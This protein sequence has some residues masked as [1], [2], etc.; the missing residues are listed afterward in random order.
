MDL[1]IVWDPIRFR[2]D[3]DVTNGDLAIDEGG[4]RSAVLV[5]LFT[6][7]AA[8]PDYVPPAG[9]PYERRGVWVDSYEPEPAGSLL[10]LLNRVA[11]SPTL[12]NQAAGY[13]SDSLQ[14]LK[15]LRVVSA[16]D[17]QS[18]W[19]QPTVIGLQVRLT[20]PVAPPFIETFGWA[21]QGV[22]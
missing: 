17:V 16:V 15:R 14:W 11:K 7:G 19:I 18:S 1:A 2:G 13:A 20:R 4:L 22:S 9:S 5:S 6:D 12:L 21:W 3:L 10:W 8:P